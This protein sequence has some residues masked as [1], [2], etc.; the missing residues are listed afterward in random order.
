LPPT[1][2]LATQQIGGI[3]KPAA[4][5]IVTSSQFYFFTLATIFVTSLFCSFIIGVVRTG[6]KNQGFKY[7][8]FLLVLSTIMYFIISA[9]LDSF[10]SNVNILI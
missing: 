6:S 2:E 3:I 4:T 8:P 9:L 10:F 1:A 5:P 7:F